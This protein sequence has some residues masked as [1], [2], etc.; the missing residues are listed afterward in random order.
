MT[1]SAHQDT[2]AR[3]RL[4]AQADW[5][6]LRFDL[7][8]L[9]FPERLNCAAALLDDAVARK[10]WGPR[11]C[12]VGADGQVW[13]YAQL[14]ARADGIAHW[15]VS[16]QGLL[17]GQ[18]VL[19]RSPNQPMLAACWMAVIK[20]GGIAVGTMPMLRAAELGQII[21]KAQISHALC[22]RSLSE[23]LQEAAASRP[24]VRSGRRPAR[25]RA[26]VAALQCALPGRGHR[27]R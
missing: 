17:P 27:R 20:A 13:T 11:A 6:E 25:H 4:P 18:R 8:E 5:P 15:L 22:D 24:V 7:P 16:S 2:F 23:A 21:D 9:Q 26:A 14:Q 3:D 1:P 19:L 12:L 10:G